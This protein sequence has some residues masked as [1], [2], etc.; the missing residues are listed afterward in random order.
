MVTFDYK[1]LSTQYRRKA[2]SSS[3]A[4]SLRDIEAETWTDCL[5]DKQKIR[6]GKLCE[7][8]GASVSQ[9]NI[10]FTTLLFFPCT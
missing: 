8:Q 6:L 9:W 4:Y 1:K 5:N 7:G 10:G 3:L 2:K